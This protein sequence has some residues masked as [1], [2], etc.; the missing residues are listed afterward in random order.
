M[1]VIWIACLLTVVVTVLLRLAGRRSISQM[2]FGSVAV[3]LALGTIIAEPIAQKSVGLTITVTAVMLATLAVLEWIQVKSDRFER[4]IT[5]KSLVVIDNGQIQ[6]ANLKKLR[7]TVDKLEMRL[8]Q[9][10]IKR[11]ADVKTATIE[12]NGSVGYELQPDKEPLTVGQF[13]Q[14]MRQFGMS[15]QSPQTKPAQPSLFDEPKR[16]PMHDAE[17]QG[18]LQ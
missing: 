10:G 6:T 8:R 14:V 11:I 3:M 9:H 7:M 12:V 15:I 1:N 4:L 13:E 5:G 17:N 2:T 16:Y 18:Q